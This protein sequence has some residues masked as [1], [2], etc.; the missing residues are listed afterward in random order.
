LKNSILLVRSALDVYPGADLFFLEY[1]FAEL[2]ENILNE[3]T[4][5]DLDPL[6]ARAPHDLQESPGHNA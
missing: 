4:H 2:L 6:L 1:V 5:L 3:I